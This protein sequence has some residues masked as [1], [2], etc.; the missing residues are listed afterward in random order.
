MQI[1]NLSK[2]FR[3]V[4]CVDSKLSQLRFLRVVHS[5]N[6]YFALHRVP[7]EMMANGGTLEAAV[8]GTAITG[9]AP[10][11]A[12]ILASPKTYCQIFDAFS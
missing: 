11:Y 8:V 10:L 6:F 3:Q 5:Q 4:F 7:F 1:K 12:P 9:I 2:V